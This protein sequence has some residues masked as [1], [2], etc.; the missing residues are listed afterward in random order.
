M[1][2]KI[3]DD[4]LNRFLMNSH[5]SFAGFLDLQCIDNFRVF[6]VSSHHFYFLLDLWF[7]AICPSNATVLKNLKQKGDLIFD[8]SLDTRNLIGQ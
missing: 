4:H 3:L 2:I 8:S 6:L 7:P 1:F 5:S